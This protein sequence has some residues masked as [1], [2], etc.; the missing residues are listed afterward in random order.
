MRTEIL[1]AA[2]DEATDLARLAFD[3]EETNCDVIVWR[4]GKS[5]P[6]KLV[7]K[8][9]GWDSERN[10]WRAR[11][12]TSSVEIFELGSIAD[13]RLVQRFTWFLLGKR[14]AISPDETLDDDA[15]RFSIFERVGGQFGKYGLM[16][17]LGNESNN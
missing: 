7:Y 11:D 14:G 12:I 10:G 2:L 9:K 6:E 3:A 17:V 13:V 5:K 16:M 1:C 4:N 15:R 8:L